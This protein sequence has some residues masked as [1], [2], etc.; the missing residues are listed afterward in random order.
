MG[1]KERLGAALKFLDD[2]GHGEAAIALHAAIGTKE[3]R[4]AAGLPPRKR[5]K[6]FDPDKVLMGD[7][8][9]TVAWRHAIGELDEAHAIDALRD[10][11]GLKLD[12]RTAT[13]FLAALAIRARPLA[14]H[15]LEG[16]AK[17]GARP[18]K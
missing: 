8:A 13:A 18:R 12:Q 3:G 17:R 4:R 5:G 16:L 1:L 6:E 2:N 14:E 9:F 10:I 15:F 11:Y 7:P